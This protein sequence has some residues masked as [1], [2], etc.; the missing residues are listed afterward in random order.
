MGWMAVWCL[1]P[2]PNQALKMIFERDVEGDQGKAKCDNGAL[3]LCWKARRV[4]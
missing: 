3:N 2:E 1:I 4:V